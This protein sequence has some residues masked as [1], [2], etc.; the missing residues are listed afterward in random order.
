MNDGANNAQMKEAWSKVVDPIEA[1]TI[2]LAN[3]MFV[4]TDP[5]YKDLNDALWNM[6][7]RVLKNHG[8][9]A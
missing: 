1:I 3:S 4:G 2:M 7:E 6:L 8:E 5:Y 9:A